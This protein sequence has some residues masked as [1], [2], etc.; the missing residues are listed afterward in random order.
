MIPPPLSH[1]EFWEKQGYP[2]F[3]RFWQV[4]NRVLEALNRLTLN[5]GKP[6]EKHHIL[7]RYLCISTGI[8]YA[9]VGLLVG[10]GCGL[11]AMKIVRTT[12]EAA[13]NAEYLRLEPAEHRQF[14][15]WSFIEQ[16]RKLEY[17]R[18]HMPT[19]YTRLDPEM[20]ANTEKRYKVVRP[21]FLQP[22]KK[23]QQSWCKRSL[24]ERAEKTKFEEMYS[25]VYMLSSELSHVSFGGLAQHVESFEEEGTQ[26]AIPPS[27]TRCAE[28][29]NSAHY[30]ALRAVGTLV[31]INDADSTPSLAAL[32]S[33]YDYA[34]SDSNAPSV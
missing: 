31:S 1:P 28:A 34:W 4:C 29:L 19:D 8:S 33:D 10:N 32:K 11:S 16:H 24:R 21:K 17:M 22:N 6:K 18:K 2:T 5:A 7:I 26:P 9:D 25:M 23:L 14:L 15:D 27:L 20:V 30:C 3:E 13:V 12:L